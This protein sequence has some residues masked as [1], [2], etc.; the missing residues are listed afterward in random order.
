MPALRS[1]AHRGGIPDDSWKK[2]QD[3]KILV[4]RNRRAVG[5][6]SECIGIGPDKD[7]P[8]LGISVI[9]DGQLAQSLKIS[10]LRLAVLQIHLSGLVIILENGRRQGSRGTPKCGA[11]DANGFGATQ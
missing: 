7:G 4:A 6:P 3:V 10:N 1:L 2:V 11:L 5:R 9:F 8:E